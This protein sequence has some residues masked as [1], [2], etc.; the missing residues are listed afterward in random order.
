[1]IL[2]DD[3][4]DAYKKLKLV[5]ERCHEYGVVLKL[6]KSFIGVDKVTFFGYE[7]QHGQATRWNDSQRKGYIQIHNRS[8]TDSSVQEERRVLT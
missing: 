2:A 3:Y 4:D 8:G 7:V 6:K 1:M 5:L